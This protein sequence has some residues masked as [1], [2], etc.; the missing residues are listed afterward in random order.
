M[1]GRDSFSER[2]QLGCETRGNFGVQAAVNGVRTRQ[3]GM[4]GR[5]SV[6]TVVTEVWGRQLGYSDGSFGVRA[7]A[8]GL[9]VWGR[10]QQGCGVAVG[11]LGPQLRCGD[12]SNRGVGGGSWN[13][14]A[15]ATVCGSQLEYGGDSKRGVGATATGVWG[16]QLGC[17]GGNGVLG[18]TVTGV[19]GR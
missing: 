17:G 11:A 1:Y 19:W 4:R 8:A 5:W 12:G 10:Q 14:W 13:A 18:A 2:R 15:A 6:G 7:P 9:R 3:P 16:R